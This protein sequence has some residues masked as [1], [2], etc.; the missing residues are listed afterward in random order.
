MK[1]SFLF[2]A[3]VLLS[4]TLSCSGGGSSSGGGVSKIDNVAGTYAFTTGT[5]NAAC[6]N[7]NSTSIPAFSQNYYIS[8]SGNI[9]TITGGSAPA[10][11]GATLLSSSP[12]TGTVDSGNNFVMNGS[13]ILAVSGVSGQVTAS[14]NYSGT[15]TTTGWSGVVTITYLFQSYNTSCRVTS[16]FSGTKQ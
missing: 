15:F 16:N 7:G 13:A 3:L 9:V 11:V 8:Q 4:L 14:I 6:S 12:P 10:P 5:M 2:L 1:K